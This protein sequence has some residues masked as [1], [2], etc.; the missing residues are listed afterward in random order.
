VLEQFQKQGVEPSGATPAEFAA[1]LKQQLADWG[2][3]ARDAGLK[4]E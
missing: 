1:F 4:P 3:A 2:R